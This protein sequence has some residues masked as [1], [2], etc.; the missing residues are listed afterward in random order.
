MTRYTCSGAFFWQDP[1][2]TS[3][4]L[5]RP[6]DYGKSL[7]ISTKATSLTFSHCPCSH[8]LTN[9]ILSVVPLA[10]KTPTS[11]LKAYTTWVGI[12]VVGSVI[13]ALF[14][15]TRSMRSCA[16][17]FPHFLHKLLYAVWI[18]FEGYVTWLL[19]W[20]CLEVG[21]RATCIT[22]PARTL[23]STLKTCSQAAT[24]QDP[25]TSRLE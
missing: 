6:K 13:G 15:I 17:D 19:Q 10:W 12:W 23:R 2:L 8:R 9:L 24:I 18:Y 5:T 11:C 7:A 21:W 3:Y 25:T 22:A 14:F 20:R 1:L 16:S 4:Q